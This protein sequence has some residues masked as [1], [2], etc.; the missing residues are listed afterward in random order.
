MQFKLVCR[1][2]IRRRDRV[3]GRWKSGR[4][5]LLAGLLAAG[6]VILGALGQATAVAPAAMVDV[7][8]GAGSPPDAGSSITSAPHPRERTWLKKRWG[9]EVIGVRWTA[10]GHMLEFRYKVLDAEKARP[11][12]ERRIKPVLIEAG[13]GTEL[14]VPTPP[15][16]GALRNSNPPLSGRTYWMFF[17]NPGGIV[18]PGHHVSIRIGEFLVDGLVVQ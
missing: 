2:G 6:L 3:P 8:R 9:V 17:D 13:T 5:G 11:L 4:R 10:A 12:F 1:P 15:T 16:T 14:K 7:S 18:R